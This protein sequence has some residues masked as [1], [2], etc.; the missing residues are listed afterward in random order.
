[1]DEHSKTIQELLEKE[2]LTPQEVTEGVVACFFATNHAFVQRRLGGSTKVDD[3]LAQ[4]ITQVFKEHEV[5][6]ANPDLHFLKQAVQ[7]L[8]DQAGFETEPELLK[9]H[10]GIIQ[11]MFA[12]AKK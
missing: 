11:T 3:S 9:N 6:P 7:T 2:S 8:D 10:Q 12:R 5:D 4:L 1:M